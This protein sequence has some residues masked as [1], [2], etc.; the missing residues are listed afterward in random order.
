MTRQLTVYAKWGQGVLEL[1]VRG[2]TLV[3]RG[4]NAELVF[5]PRSIL[6]E[7]EY[8]SKRDLADG[9]R[10]RLYIDFA[11]EFKPL[12]PRRIDIV[13]TRMIGLFEIRVTDL[14][15]DRFLT[16]ITPGSFL[17]TYIVLST[18]TLMVETSAK[19]KIFYEEEPFTKLVIHIM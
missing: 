8:V 9:K 13:G 7:A 10:K 14:D 3:V 1:I 2:E 18:K 16:V 11:S 4:A 6:V 19:R 15:F 12:E 5:E 17:Y